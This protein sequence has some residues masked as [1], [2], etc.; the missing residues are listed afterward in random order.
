MFHGDE[1]I[2]MVFKKNENG[3]K[4][5][6]V[7]TAH[8]NE[9]GKYIVQSGVFKWKNLN[10]IPTFRTFSDTE[11]VRNGYARLLSMQTEFSNMEE[12][13]ICYIPEKLYEIL[14]RYQRIRGD[15]V[16]HEI[17]C[18]LGRTTSFIHTKEQAFQVTHD[19]PQKYQEDIED[20]T[21]SLQGKQFS[22]NDVENLKK[23]VSELMHKQQKEIE[24]LE[25][26]FNDGDN[27]L[28]LIKESFELALRQQKEQQE[29]LDKIEEKK[30]FMTGKLDILEIN[31]TKRNVDENSKFDQT[32]FEQQQSKLNMD[33][34]KVISDVKAKIVGQD[35]AVEAVVA[36]IYANQMLIDTGNRD[37]ISTQKAA[38]LIDGPTGTGKT[39]IVKEVADK[40]EIPMVD[41]PSTSFSA[42]GYV[43]D[44]ITE[45]LVK[46]YKEA[47]G[48]LEL[49]QRG[50]VVIDEIDKLGGFSKEKELSMRKAVQQE[51]L[52]FISGSKYT[53]EIGGRMGP[54]VEFDT[55]N[56]TF[57]SLG[58]FTS[59][60]D[61]KIEEKTKQTKKTII[62]FVGTSE[63]PQVELEEEKTYVMNEQDYIEYGLE[64]ELVGRISLFAS[65]KA[66]TK[67]G[68]RRILLESEISPLKTF[69][70]FA[71]SFGVEEVIYDDEFIEKVC[72]MAYEA[73][74]GARG[75]HQIISNLKNIL[76]IDIINNK[77]KTITLTVDMLDK[78]KEKNIRTY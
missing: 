41:S 61:K 74:F 8:K 31:I 6:G 62:G 39:A 45:I 28:K 29:L 11:L 2:L 42:T 50:I 73:N 34:N 24:E 1:R 57:I 30:K 7:E 25:Y 59:I 47:K 4:F 48:D 64:R 63:V 26:R 14:K 43:G 58:A 53:I 33:V 23:E 72:E 3:Y 22:F 49:A 27:H 78:V 15:A 67:E 35:E 52:T 65:T 68:Y 5:H 9:E 76:L 17:L 69:I 60:R 16:A 12:Y 77:S 44:S 56:L 38:I 55:T 71:K 13:A 46:L 19:T 10:L 54:K 20:I 36:N 66:Y 70:D 40:L 51:L 37:L 21:R 32:A 75:L 18:E